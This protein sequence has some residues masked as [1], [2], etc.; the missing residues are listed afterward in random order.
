MT[1]RGLG[2]VKI[3]KIEIPEALVNAL[4]DRDKGLVVFAGPP[5]GLRPNRSPV[6][7]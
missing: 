6:D 5:L 7:K 4:R 2:W 3:G 1:R